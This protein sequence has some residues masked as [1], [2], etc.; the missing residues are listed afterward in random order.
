MKKTFTL[1]VS[2]FLGLQLLHAQVTIEVSEEIKTISRGDQPAFVVDIPH[3]VY[4]TI[5]KD[6]IKFLES[7]TKLK[8]EAISNELNIHGAIFKKI[9]LDSVNVYSSV[10]NLDS[11]VRVISCFE[12]DSV[13]ISSMS[14]N[15]QERE[16]AV[17]LKTAVRD[18]AVEQYIMV[19]DEKLKAENAQL[20][21]LEKERLEKEDAIE[22]NQKSIKGDEESIR[23]SEESIEIIEGDIELK[24]TEI[25]NKKAVVSSLK[26]YD[27]E[28]YKVA[29]KELSGLEREKKKM[30]KN[31]EK[32]HKNIV[33]YKNDIKEAERSIT[34]L[35][36]EVEGVEQKISDQKDRIA[37]IEDEKKRIR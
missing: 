36:E 20:Q 14:E 12:L 7:G 15:P 26:S 3:G 4:E 25:K 10:Y 32:E 9:T 1:F 33:E 13:F 16:L 19:Y 34:L 2:L 24:N 5:Q 6:W 30:E 35:E 21:A 27:P 23:R 8:V 37:R 29:G 11:S 31:R 22:K 28:G 18:F 17:A